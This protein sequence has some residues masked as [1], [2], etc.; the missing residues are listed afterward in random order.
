MGWQVLTSKNGL[1][2]CAIINQSVAPTCRLVEGFCQRSQDADCLDCML[3]R[4]DQSRRL[5]QSVDL[6]LFLDQNCNCCILL[7]KTH[8][9]YILL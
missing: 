3:A 2:S 9:T 5:L 4:L 6:R 7:I 1:I 8:M